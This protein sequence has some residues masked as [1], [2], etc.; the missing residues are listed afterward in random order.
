MASQNHHRRSIRLQ[1]YDYA[2]AGAYFIT[3]CTQNRHHLFGKIIDGKMAL[4]D[5]GGIVADEWMKTA[6]IRN[7]IKLDEWV[8]MP[9]HF[10]GILIIE[11]RSTGTARRAPTDARRP[12]TRTPTEQFG[13]P[14]SGSLPTIIRSF[15]SAVTKRVN[16]IRNMPGAKLWQRNYWEHIIRNEN[17]YHRIAQYIHDNPA[18]W[19]N[20]RLNDKTNHVVMESQADYGLETWMV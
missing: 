16:E 1:G 18:K 10:H 15:K 4:N 8:I 6:E 20:D 14:V 7:N 9:N 17:E 19:E 13:K 2:Q 5:V 12:P 3:V 11:S